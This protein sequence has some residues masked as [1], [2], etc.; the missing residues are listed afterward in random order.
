L[1]VRACEP[2]RTS[3]E[4]EC[5]LLKLEKSECATYSHYATEALQALKAA[6]PGVTA[7]VV[8]KPAQQSIEPS[9]KSV[10]RRRLSDQDK[11]NLHT[12]DGYLGSSGVVLV[13]A[14]GSQLAV[15]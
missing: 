2:Y 15:L 9:A 12:V 5:V 13:E 10:A 14:T 1:L 6:L 8:A 11:D 3:P 4:R 7:D